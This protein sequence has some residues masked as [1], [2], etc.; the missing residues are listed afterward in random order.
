MARLGCRRPTL[1]LAA[2]VIAAS[3]GLPMNGSGAADRVVA[4]TENQNG[5]T[6]EITRAQKLEIRLPVQGGTGFS[7]ELTHA[8]GAA[9]RLA[10]SKVL[11]GS[12]GARP[13]G[14]QIQLLVFTPTAA[15]ADDIELG[16]RR[17]WEKASP[18]ARTFVVHV[19]VRDA[20]R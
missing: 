12:T 5:G 7:W 18:P 13:G 8:P 14:A 3:T 10:S 15:G 20:A 2:T 6:V 17:P 11:P 4:V 16:Y 1:L 19:V 9:V